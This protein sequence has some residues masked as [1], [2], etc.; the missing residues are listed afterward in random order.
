MSISKKKLGCYIPLLVVIT[1]IIV[2]FFVAAYGHGAM[3]SDFTEEEHIAR[4]SQLV[5][6]RYFNEESR[7][8]YTDYTVYPLYDQN[9]KLTH[10]LVEFEPYGFVYIFLNEKENSPVVGIVATPVSLYS[11]HLGEGLYWQR[12][13]LE[14]DKRNYEVDEKGEYIYYRD[15]HYKIADIKNEKRYMI[16]TYNEHTQ[17]FPA[18]KRGD[19]FLNLISMQEFDIDEIDNQPANISFMAHKSDQNL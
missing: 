11:R 17:Y 2:L 1:T 10:F 12:Y 13:T 5:E 9:D 19:K 6:K 4:I 18:V 8:E 15:S 14:D 16:K 7:Y 3:A